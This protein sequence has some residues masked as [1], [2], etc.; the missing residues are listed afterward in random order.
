[1]FK[2]FRVLLV[3]ISLS[4]SIGLMSSTYSKYVANTTGNIDASFSKWQIFV[5]TDDI[6]SSSNSLISITPTMEDSEHVANNVIAPTTKGW[7]DIDIDPTNVD[8]SFRYF[9]D[10]A[11][12]NDEMPDLMITEYAI[13][14]G[15]YNEG[16]NLDITKVTDGTISNTLVYNKNTEDFRFEAFTVRIFFE[17]YEGEDETMNDEADTVLAKKAVT[18]AAKLSMSASL[19]FE[20]MI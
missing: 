3:L 7:F 4:V 19:S 9:I 8:V 14:P 5:N 6:T 10:L 20:Q 12:D 2:K 13:I 11:I 17:W 18:E 15:D 16:D 1:M